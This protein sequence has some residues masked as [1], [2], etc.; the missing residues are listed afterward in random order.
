LRSRLFVGCELG[1]ELGRCRIRMSDLGSS[2]VR[3]FFESILTEG[4]LKDCL[5]LVTWTVTTAL[6]EI[7]RVGHGGSHLSNSLGKS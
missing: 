4:G 6:R 5:Y 3:V 1:E 2:P 7:R